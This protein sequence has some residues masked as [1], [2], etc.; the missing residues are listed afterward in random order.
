MEDTVN[1]LDPE[2]L[3]RL[4]DNFIK[5]YNK[6]AANRIAGHQVPLEEVYRY[7]R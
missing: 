4:N 2:L 1:P 5:L 7:F 6:Y 3:P